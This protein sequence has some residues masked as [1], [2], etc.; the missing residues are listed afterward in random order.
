MLSLFTSIASAQ[1]TWQ[2]V[3]DIL[4]VNCS[5]PTCHG[6]GNY[7]SSYNVDTTPAILYSQIINA[8]PT[9]PYAKDTLGN[10]LIA[11][12]SPQTS[13]IMRKLSHCASGPLGLVNMLFEGDTMPSGYKLTD[14]E[15]ELIL[16]WILDGAPQTGVVSP[17]TVAGS[18][19]QLS[20][21][22]RIL[23]AE[24]ISFTIYPNP[25]TEK[26]SCSYTLERP[27]LV[28]M[29][30][31]DVTGRKMKTLLNENQIAGKQLKTVALEANSGV[32]FLRLK[33]GNTSQYMKKIILY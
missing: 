1:S 6:S 14:A 16:T 22:V 17:D 29:E 5:T 27:S 18:I 32:Y 20:L 4:H 9:N 26:F 31:I 8:D 23:P 21:A 12:G 10:K 28:T 15:L 13:F 11:P 7:N 30:L 2:D 3:Y 25:T 19:C 33:L 24:D